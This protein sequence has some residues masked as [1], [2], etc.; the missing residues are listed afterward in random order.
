MVRQSN[1]P[2]LMP[3]PA[4]PVQYP[5]PGIRLTRPDGFVVQ[6]NPLNPSLFPGSDGKYRIDHLAPGRYHMD[7]SART[8]AYGYPDY[9]LGKPIVVDVQAG[10]PNDIV[11]KVAAKP[12]E[13]AERAETLA[14]G[15]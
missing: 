15:G 3:T 5:H 4:S 11:L 6:L 8:Y 2:F 10:K 14:L 9:Q 12:V 1:S 7:V 13:D